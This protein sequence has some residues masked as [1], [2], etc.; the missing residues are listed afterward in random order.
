MEFILLLPRMLPGKGTPLASSAVLEIS[1]AKS[2]LYIRLGAG[3][4]IFALSLH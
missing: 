3:F 2:E 4:V 1:P